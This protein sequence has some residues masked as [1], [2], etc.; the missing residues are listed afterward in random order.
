MSAGKTK[1]VKNKLK[2]GRKYYFTIKAYKVINGKKVYGK[3]VTKK[4]KL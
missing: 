4:I 1:Y 3:F 2:S